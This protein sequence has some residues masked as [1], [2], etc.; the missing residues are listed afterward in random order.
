MGPTFARIQF[1]LP[2]DRRLNADTNTLPV[3][4]PEVPTT[5]E[6]VAQ[7]EEVISK[8]DTLVLRSAALLTYGAARELGQRAQFA[9]L[10]AATSV[11]LG[12]GPR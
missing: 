5:F 1:K 2:R 9:V 10:I 11:R 12:G 7:G 6:L 3:G 8:S 4:R